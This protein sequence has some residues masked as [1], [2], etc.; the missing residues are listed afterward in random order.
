MRQYNNAKGPGQLFS[1]E[2]MDETAAIRAT[3][4]NDNATR[5]F[6]LLE[7]GKVVVVSRGSVKP[8]N[9]KF[10]NSRHMYEIMF[11]S[12]TVITPVRKSSFV[13][14][15]ANCY[16]INQCADEGLSSMPAVSYKFV[17]IDQLETI[18]KDQYVDILAVITDIG[19][20]QSITVKST[21]KQTSKRDLTLT[22][23]SST[24]VKMTLWNDQAE[25]FHAPLHAVIAVSGARVSD[26][27]GTPTIL[28]VLCLTGEHRSLALDGRLDPR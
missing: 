5:L 26:F 17:K 28:C 19:D 20:T 10:N 27:N 11:D 6:P 21:G 18:N 4:F 16:L 14:T 1:V 3:A 8:A 12:N 23:A 7:P 24:S 15:A 2:L 22:D 9:T 13:F 25:N